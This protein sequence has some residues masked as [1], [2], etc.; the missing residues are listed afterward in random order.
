MIQCQCPI[1]SSMCRLIA[2][3]YSKL[4]Y[5]TITFTIDKCLSYCC[6]PLFVTSDLFYLYKKVQINVFNSYNYFYSNTLRE[7]KC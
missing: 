1:C 7:L 2:I 4:S 3:Q 6:S 5:F